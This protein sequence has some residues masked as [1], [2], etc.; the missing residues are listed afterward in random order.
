MSMKFL[1]RYLAIGGVA[2]SSM[3]FGHSYRGDEESGSVYTMSNEV[4][5][6]RI[7]SFARGPDGTLTTGPTYATGG[8]GTGGSLGNQGGVVGNGDFLVAVNAGSDDIS[9][10][11]VDA[12]GLKLVDRM[13][14]GGIRPVSVTMD[15]HLVYVLNA[16]SDSI[17]GFWM[18]HSGRLHSL[19]G[20][21][22]DLSATGTGPAQI[23]LGRDGRTLIVT[24]KATNKIV[25]FALN[26]YG[27]PS[28][29]HVIDSAAPT[30]FGFAV[31]KRGRVV[32]SEAVGGAPDASV[33]SSY[34]IRSSGELEVVDPAVPTTQTA[35]CWVVITP[36]G[37]FAYTTNTGS[38]SISTYRVRGNGDLQLLAAVGASTGAG[39]GPIDMALSDDGDFLYV[40]NSG[41]NSIAMFQVSPDGALQ[42]VGAIGG[43]PGSTN[44]LVAF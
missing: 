32:V 28:A 16:G 33:L 35:A 24:E 43:L 4:A 8:N 34:R 21:E 13:P 15:H 3:A 19:P 30:P 29:K 23:Q 22:Q 5:G 25:T 39:S 12:R 26:R 17:A 36:N 31:T 38:G 6:N 7:L 37:R 41:A 42:A 11:K 2:L 14:S 44:G 27:V 1:L 10:F 9:V 20:S 18:S 40:L